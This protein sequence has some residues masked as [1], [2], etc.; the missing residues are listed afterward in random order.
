M[1]GLLRLCSSQIRAT[2]GGISGVDW[3]AVEM[4]ALKKGID[5]SCSWL[6]VESWWDVFR[7]VEYEWCAILN[8]PAP[9][10]EG[11]EKS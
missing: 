8:K 3:N 9:K 6:G 4:V 7:T 1:I 11:G 10:T 2:F 5:T